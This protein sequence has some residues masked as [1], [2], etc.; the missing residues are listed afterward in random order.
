M[1]PLE[2][3]EQLIPYDAEMEADARETNV[4][5]ASGRYVYG[6]TSGDACHVF[7]FD[8]ATAKIGFDFPPRPAKKAAKKAE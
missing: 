1:V 7:R 3:L 4:L 2:L 6:A 8:P 5:V